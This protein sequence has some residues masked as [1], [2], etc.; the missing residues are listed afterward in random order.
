LPSD[1]FT[2]IRL[3]RKVQAVQ[4]YLDGLALQ[5]RGEDYATY[6][7]GGYPHEAALVTAY[8]MARVPA[9]RPVLQADQK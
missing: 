3:D 8:T 5:R 1:R 6:F 2:F 4:A 9:L 7:L